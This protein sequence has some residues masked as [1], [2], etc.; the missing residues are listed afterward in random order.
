MKLQT[1]QHTQE[2]ARQ[3]EAAVVGKSL[4][5]AAATAMTVGGKVAPEVVLPSVALLE[6]FTPKAAP[7]RQID[8]PEFKVWFGKSKVV[9]ADGQPLVVH[10]GTHKRFEQFE[11]GRVT[12]NFMWGMGMDVTRLGAFFSTEKTQ[13]KSFAK[14]GGTVIPVYLSIQKPAD[15]H[16]GFSDEIWQTFYDLLHDWNIHIQEPN[17]MWE[18]FDTGTVG[19]PEFVAALKAHGY[20]GA[21][22]E[23]DG[24]EVW[25]AFEP[26]QIK[27]AKKN[28]GAFDPASPDIL[29]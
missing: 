6:S 11:I 4:S 26:T 7:M 9:G 19:G 5:W 16:G 17:K 21:R 27:H 1:P 13:A 22:I 20:D 10:H 2:A 12:E 23:E 28:C 18:L 8:T 29:R 15:L 24:C 3:A 14:D 25:V